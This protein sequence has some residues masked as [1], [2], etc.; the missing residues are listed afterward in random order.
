MRRARFEHLEDRRL[1]AVDF[2]DAPDTALGTGVGNYNTLSTDNGPQHTIVVGL[3]MGASVDGDGGALQNAAANA[4]DVNA[5]LP[6]DEDG[7]VNPTADLV[8]TEGTQPTIDVW[9]TNTSGSTATLYGW[10]D[11]NT[12]GVFD[13]VTERTSVNVANGTTDGV[14]TL[15][16]PTVPDGI[17]GTTYARFR[18]S[19]DTAAA[20][21]TGAAADG[22]VEDYRVNVTARSSG[23]VDNAKSEKIAH[24][25][26]GRP[27]LDNS[28]YF[29]R[30]VAAI[31]DI[32]GD[33]ITDLAVGAN[34]DDTIGNER[35]V[36]HIF[37]MNPDGSARAESVISSGQ[38]GLANGDYFGS[39]VASIGDL[40]GDG[41][42]DVAV[43]AERADVSNGTNVGRLHVVYLNANGTRKSSNSFTNY[44]NPGAY[45]GRSVTGIGDL[46]GDG[47][48][49]LAV[50]AYGDDTGG[51]DRG[52]VYVAF[53]D[54]DGDPGLQR[55]IASNSNGGPQL[56][57]GDKFGSSLA[58]IGDLDG[59]GV[60]DLA[61]G[62]VGDDTGGS[63]RGAVHI[64]FMNSDGT[65]KSTQKIASG[66]AGGP[67]L[68]DGDQFGRSVASLGDLDGD[69]V[70]DLAVGSYYDDTGGSARGAIHV[71]FMNT[72]G[73]VKKSHKIAS[74]TN[75]GPT[76]SNDDRFGVS[77]TSM[78]DLDGDGITDLAVGANF[79]DTGGINRGAV[80]MLFLGEELI[81][82]PPVFTSPAAVDVPENSTSVM[83]VTAD[84]AEA[85]PQVVTFS[86]AGGADQD[87][88]A[89]TSDGE[90]SFID[91]PDFEM[92]VDA[93]GNNVYVVT[94]EAND[95][96]GGTVSQTISVTVTPVN[97]YSPKFTSPAAVEMPE[98]TLVVQTVTATDG[99]LPSQ[100]ITF[101][102]SPSFDANLFSITNDGVLSF[103]EA[104]DY[105]SPADEGQDNTYRVT[106]GI[107]DGFSSLYRVV[108]ITVTPTND[109]APVFTSPS[110]A[111]VVEGTLDVLTVVATDADL[112]EQAIS[113]DLEGGADLNRFSID[114]SGLLSFIT[115]PDYDAPSD[116]NGDNVYEALVTASDGAGEF[117][118]QPISVRV[119]SGTD[120]GDA[121]DS[122]V[123]TG[124][125]NY[126]TLA[127]DN[128]ARHTLVTGLQ[129][130]SAIDGDDG[131]LSN[132]SALADD[133]DA[134][135]PDDEDGLVSPAT[136]LQLTIG[137]TPTIAMRVTNS[138]GTT[139]ILWGWVDYNGDGAFDNTTERAAV[140]VPSGTINEIAMLTL[141]M[142]TGDLAGDT[143]ARF[144]LSTDLAAADSTG[145]ALDGEVEDYRVSITAQSDGTVD[146][147]AT[148]KI[149][150]GIA[151]SPALQDLDLFGRA[152][153]GIGD[154]DGDGVR[155]VA[156]GAI[157]DDS[158]RGAVYVLFMNPDGTIKD[159]TEIAS[160]LNGGPAL[161]GFDRFGHSIASLGDLDADGVTDLAVGAIAVDTGGT[162]RGAVFVLFMNPNGSVKS[163]EMIA[164]GTG[165]GPA[166]SNGD[167]FGVGVSAVGDLD[168]DGIVDL[169][170]GANQDDTGGVDRGA[171]HLLYMNADG[172]AKATQ[173][174]ASG[175]NGGPVLADGD[176]FGRS[177]STLGDLDG[178]GR[179]ELVVGAPANSASAGAVYILSLN[180]N[181]TVKSTQKIGSDI[182][183]G[184]LLPAGVAFGAAV[185][186]AGDLDGDG[187][188]DLVA[189]A[190]FDRT[191]S[192]TTGAIHILFMNSDG[193]VRE[194]QKIAGNI[195]GGPSLN[196]GG[197]FGDSVS[198]I[199]DLNGDGVTELIVGAAND[200]TGGPDRGAAYV[201]FLNDLNTDPVFTSPTSVNVPE[202]STT[203]L[204]V[205]AEDSD[206]PP[207]TLSYSLVGGND[208]SS[209]SITSGGVLSF[210]SP[211]DFETP[212]D[213][214]GDNIYEVVVRVSDGQEGEATQ[215]LLVNV[216]P[217]N[218]NDPIFT[219]TSS[220]DVPENI[221]GILSLTAT[222][223]DAPTQSITFSVAGGAD[224]GQF[225]V[226]PGG[227][228]SF[229][230][231][232]DFEVPMD[233]NGDNVY[234][235]I[236][237][238]SDGFGGLSQQSITVMV[239]PE[240]DNDPVFITPDQHEVLEGMT[241]VLQIAAIDDDL[242][243]QTVTY[244][245]AGGEDVDQFSLDPAGQLTFDVV[246]DFFSPT[247]ANG[248]N[249]YEVT[250]EANDGQGGTTTQMLSITVVSNT[251]LG[252][253]PDVQ[254]GTDI[255]DYQT[256]FSDNGPRH[257]I[258]DGL[259]LGASVDGDPGDLQNFLA[260]ADDVGAALPDDEDGVSNPANDLVLTVGTT[261]SINL[262]VTNTTADPATLYGWVDYN[263][264]GVFDNAT[265]RASVAVPA[266]TDGEIATL[267]FPSIPYGVTGTTYARFRLSSDVAAADPVGLAIDGEVEDYRATIVRA[268][269]GTVDPASTVAIGSG[270]GNGPVV[271]D[272]AY[273]GNS[274]ANIGDLDNDGISDLAVGATGD[275]TGGSRSG[276]I[277][278]L[279]MNA[280]GTV[281]NDTKIAHNTSGGPSLGVLDQFGRSI[282][283]LGDLDGDGVT[284]LAVG[285]NGTLSGGSGPG[286][287]YV[288]FMNTD[289]T[290]KNSTK[291][292]N[293]LNGGPSIGNGDQ[294][295]WAVGSLGD[296][297]GDGMTDLA[298][299]SLSDSTGGPQRGAVH[300]LFLNTDG[301]VKSSQ[302]IASGVGGGPVLSDDDFFGRS[303]TAIDD[304]NG[305]G[306][307]ELVVGSVRDDTGGDNRGAVYVLFMNPDGTV[308]SYQKIA[309]DT[310]GGPTLTDGDNFGFSVSPVGDL[311]GDGV[312]DLAVGAAY[313]DSGGAD[314]GAVHVLY[315]N[316]DGSVK[317]TG[318][319]ASDL[320]G[321]PTIADDESF[322]SGVT[323][324]GD[325]NGDGVIDLAVGS[326]LADLGGL[327]RG[328]VRVLF[329]DKVNTDPVF[330]SPN[331]VAVAE[332]SASVLTVTATDADYPPQLVN[333]SIVGGVD[334][335]AFT[336]TEQ[337]ELSFVA[338]PDY[339]APTDADGDNI[340][341]VAVEAS[342][343][344]G[345]TATQDMLVTVTAEN[346][347][348]PVFT[349]PSAV[350]VQE[351]TTAVL[352]VAA[353]DADLPEQ[354]LIYSIVGGTDETA[355]MIT[356]DGTL[357]FAASP[358]YEQPADVD[359]NNTYEVTILAY[360]GAG[361]E[362]TQTINVSVTPVDDNSPIF[363][364]PDTVDVEENTTA[365]LT[366]VA[367]DTDQP[368]QA[369]TYS[370]VGGA[371]QAKFD[372]TSGGELT[373]VEGLDFESPTDANGDGIYVVIVQ[374]TDGVSP[375]FQA[376][377]VTVVPVND[378]DPVFTSPSAVGVDENTTSVLT[379]TATDADLPA[380][381]ITFTLVGGADQAS[382]SITSAGELSFN[383]APDFEM[384]VD[385]DGNN[386]YE[387]T[388]EATD[389]QL[390]T[391]MQTVLVTVEDV[392]EPSFGDFNRD[393]RVNL[394][395]YVVW[396]NN[397]GA[398]D[399]SSIN[400][401]GDGMNGV[402][403]ADYQLWK[404]NFGNTYPVPVAALT[405]T[406]AAMSASAT[407]G[408][409]ATGDASNP[410]TDAAF[411]AYNS[412][413]PD[414]TA[415]QSSRGESTTTSSGTND[416]PSLLLLLDQQEHDSENSQPVD[417][418]AS[419]ERRS[420]RSPAT[421]ESS[422]AVVF[423]DWR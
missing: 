414:A 115:P 89:I 386:V 77:I 119:V 102:I 341:E 365:L 338:P 105:E 146:S 364:T 323:S 361:G 281:K 303:L 387:V 310:L 389:G 292:A 39:S 278:V 196:V 363:T 41:I 234:E 161:N 398:S 14:S 377:L 174:I 301:T 218:D 96:D 87:K 239:T 152:V 6:D 382:F 92:P 4:D 290:V 248:D 314:R 257:R 267:I 187:V 168:G 411:A 140:A 352:T 230:S 167:L 227:V 304:L 306:R 195:N 90:L 182:G 81:N 250:I 33:G 269:D 219:S 403:A 325:L 360:D 274:V 347:N 355:F 397:L 179:P 44:A 117:T 155:D 405:A 45:F 93:N 407:T 156:V 270:I 198:A 166:L 313:D 206:L 246:T 415:T 130:G 70:T 136:D 204:T 344:D 211:P 72:D 114:S 322:G 71:L 101:S 358:D 49:D 17:A 264:D 111:N 305:D 53:M 178:D 385:S 139:A 217:V 175:L 144:R 327:N 59:D 173:K 148:Q 108:T 37:L 308:A 64:L 133:L 362:Q 391:T 216:T 63:D 171:V 83:T 272:N 294:F 8:L 366:V 85:P 222:D 40:D 393:G 164:S 120:F 309:S 379:V 242:P 295:G 247:D 412:P 383:E 400:D 122:G 408:S 118:T 207:Q 84:D 212:S 340:Y 68:T 170:V 422:L 283:A 73:T 418:L 80:H 60:T 121:P 353:T 107:S 409:E 404:D 296:F 258:V 190:R 262:W 177:V 221:T 66:T 142:V 332:N 298:V 26:I 421:L 232:A 103:K 233:F 265:E 159:Q 18:L 237:E 291:I 112:P 157:G 188:D 131:L 375:T 176:Q 413:E 134:A 302:K 186:T 321:G 263:A 241:D 22:E 38:I 138:T 213:D 210:S 127:A 47:I 35:G 200:A 91:A 342:D 50:G 225:D 31:G 86:I 372:I 320:S 243:A 416:Q 376:I 349:T 374:A 326:E 199:G 10:I 297:D 240:N 19:T 109:N 390:G 279:F 99:D 289:G 311:D 293:G 123:G 15:L 48:L 145:L 57:D 5:A 141:P 46:D 357:S 7:L 367:T 287:V 253:A 333:F 300:V 307:G 194:S 420:Q 165:G 330:S 336:I 100:P 266:G 399:E 255:N 116:A 95:G 150:S 350:D 24:N 324:L 172:T 395:D 69:G 286:A 370:I 388:V 106:V 203:V 417:S 205:T 54:S 181:G 346:D 135:L 98:N 184:P 373:L 9:V 143:Y 169:A 343:G 43:G 254:P 189:G 402:D 312:A 351:N 282:T 348:L 392:E 345:G 29:G 34:G 3:Q 27:T 193:T 315:L 197:E 299:G 224:Q 226:S 58:N 244:T 147:T 202:N 369:I 129:L 23:L 192:D 280:D 51:A 104:P 62:A 36:L 331:A 11:Y 28:D 201:L 151:G 275:S 354:T 317:G 235:V 32:D 368:P 318:K 337:G 259:R 261:P 82:T 328:A 329:L 231:P 124:A 410:A 158:G 126:Q 25:G 381:D 249:V 74:G 396:R 251:D 229:A 223:D 245:L 56:T 273:L 110:T 180:P 394:A 284:E 12:D 316:S 2:G 215:S 268:S 276:A 423:D 220:V 285:A 65:A 76:L 236:V 13:N 359:G 160:S 42:T 55:N 162:N 378:N 319:I 288:L 163:F 61:V 16:F 401:N 335:G 339:E 20:S 419:E 132:S 277:Y 334:D 153:E 30:S 228:L 94:V 384:P 371:D 356:E 137:T 52:S 78:G 125:G 209:F 256:L 79:D 149:A 75:G 1:L 406:V 214:N 67:T 154:L 97:D 21:P 271:A 252:D 128:G 113:Y 380:Q 183:G 208:Q 191:A 88:F 260:Q 238:A 185:E